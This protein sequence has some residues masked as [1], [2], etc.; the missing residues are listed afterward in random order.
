MSRRL[1]WVPARISPGPGVARDGHTSIIHLCGA[2]RRNGTCPYV[3]SKN[4]FADVLSVSVHQAHQI[5]T[6]GAYDTGHALHASTMSVQERRRRM[7]RMLDARARVQLARSDMTDEIIQARGYVSMVPGSIDDGP[8][9]TGTRI[10]RDQHLQPVLLNGAFAGA[11]SC[12]GEPAPCTWSVWPDVPRTNNHMS[13]RQRGHPCRY[14][15]RC[16][17]STGGYGWWCTLWGRHWTRSR[18]DRSNG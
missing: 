9:G 4:R 14:R 8:I 6:G 11:L 18:P 13:R 16:A 5:V 17:P 1:L 15:P 12:W 10:H 3:P 2:A 7:T